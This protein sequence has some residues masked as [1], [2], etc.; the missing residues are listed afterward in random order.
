[1]R[2][3]CGKQA[4]GDDQLTGGHAELH[5]TEPLPGLSLVLHN[6]TIDSGATYARSGKLARGHDGRYD[7]PELLVRNK[8]SVWLCPFNA[9]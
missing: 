3:D 5:E 1:M 9:W 8:A 7:R 4:D 2:V 6:N